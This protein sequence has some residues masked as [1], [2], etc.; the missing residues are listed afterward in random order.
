MTVP[1]PESRKFFPEDYALLAIK[2]QKAI[3]AMQ[4]L[5]SVDLSAIKFYTFKML[6]SAGIDHVIISATG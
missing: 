4:S 2:G 3:E 5:T 6:I 1:R